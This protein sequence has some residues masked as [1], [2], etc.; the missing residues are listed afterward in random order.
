M[1]YLQLRLRSGSTGIA[2]RWLTGGLFALLSLPSLGWAQSADLVANISNAEQSTAVVGDAFTYTVKLSNNGNW[3]ADGAAFTI[4]LPQN[5]IDVAAR[6]DQTLA[7]NGAVCPTD[8]VVSQPPPEPA[9]IKGT[10]PTLPDQGEVQITITGTYGIG[11]PTSVSSDVNIQPPAGVTELYEPSNSSKISTTLITDAKLSVNKTQTTAGGVTTYTITVKNDGNAAADGASFKDYLS[12]TF[13]TDAAHQASVTAN[14][15]SCSV[16]GGAVCPAASEFKGFTDVSG[17]FFAKTLFNTKVPKLPAGSSLTV[18]YKATIT[19]KMDV[20]GIVTSDLM[21][22]ATITPPNGITNQ[23][24]TA[25]SRAVVSVPGTAACPP[26]PAWNYDL[27]KT[28]AKLWPDGSTTPIAANGAN[29]TYGDTIRYTV[30]VINNGTADADGAIFSDFTQSYASGYYANLK[31]KYVPSCVAENGAQCPPDASFPSVDRGGDIGENTTSNGDLFSVAIPKFPVGGKITVVYDAVLTPSQVCDIS[32]STFG[33]VAYIQPPPGSTGFTYKLVDLTVKVPETPACPDVQISKTQ[34]TTT[35][36]P[37]VPFEYV[38]TVFNNGPGAADGAEWSD[39]IEGYD[40]VRELKAKIAYGGCMAEGGAQ[41]PSEDRFNSSDSQF[42][43]YF[44]LIKY[45]TKIPKLPNQGKI[46]LRYQVTLEELVAA[47]CSSAGSNIMNYT[48]V[49]SPNAYSGKSAAVYMPITCADIG[50]TETVDPVFLKAGEPITYTVDVSN[51]G[52]SA[53]ANV[54]FSDPLPPIFEYTGATCEMV[55]ESGP[56]LPHPRT[57]CGASVDYDPAT[58]KLSSTIKSLGQLGAVRFTITGKA[59]TVPGTYKN[60]SFVTLPA[61]VFD[62][63]MTTNRTDA[64]VQIQNTHSALTVKK[65]L[66]GLPASGLTVDM[67]LTGKVTCGNQPPQNWSITVPA[68]QS[69]GASAPLT[70]YDTDVCTVTEDQPLPT[71]PAGYEWSGTPVIANSTDP[72]G[73]QTPREVPVTNTLKRLTAGLSLTKLVTGAAAAVEK[74]NGSFEFALDCGADGKFSSSVAIANGASGS[75]TISGIPVGASCQ[76]SETGKADAP[77]GYE[78]EAP[79]ISPNPIVIPPAGGSASAQA[80]NPLKRHSGSLALTKLISGPS[81]GVKKISGKFA[82]AID[83]G[84]GGNFN[85]DVEI[86]DGVSNSVTV[87]NLPPGASCQ[88]NES[89]AADAPL[90]YTWD[91]PVYETNPVVIPAT[92]ASASFKVTNVLKS[93][94]ATDVTPV[95]ALKGPLLA[96]LAALMVALGAWLV[97]RHKRGFA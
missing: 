58:H 8:M 29:Y 88:I 3:A 28:Q 15:E 79:V 21:N 57:E 23:F 33:N 31:A 39:Y 18:V 49:K 38:V 65:L 76:I 6:C 86:T 12:S 61:G 83:C 11:S 66:A 77:N 72:L 54:L 55:K 90:G 36:Q 64:N 41:C 52:L 96:A 32:A 97:R 82:F 22:T 9:T 51:A 7:I 25:L 44:Y 43:S 42:L 70:F 63:I 34:S 40:F 24:G 81:A 69:T 85:T 19:P 5:A 93:D 87:G 84:T 14:Y 62:P 26:T 67:T 92:G 78:W 46:T 2:R 95:P 89:S 10:V 74:V 75:S 50:I 27:T 13:Y 94:A 80:T 59:G 68:G 16:T 20:C 73:P 71:A 17:F 4:H 35:P 47:S 48:S 60:E 45:G 91:K 30:T 37:G 56:A 1:A 53:V